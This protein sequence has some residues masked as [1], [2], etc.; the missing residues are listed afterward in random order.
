MKNN[1]TSIK[2]LV[3]VLLYSPAAHL[4]NVALPHDRFDYCQGLV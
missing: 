2:E 3:I 1:G 4:L